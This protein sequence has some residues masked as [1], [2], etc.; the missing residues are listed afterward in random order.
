MRSISK[1]VVATAVAG[2]CGYA[3]AGTITATRSAYSLESALA[4]SA[5]VVY[6]G[7]TS[8]A[9]G[10]TALKF[11]YQ[12]QVGNIAQGQRL[13]ITST[14]RVFGTASA[15]TQT[16][17]C[18]AAGATSV[19]FV[20]AGTTAGTQVVYDVSTAATG[21]G[22]T[23]SCSIPSVAFTAAS[24]ASAGD[25][26]LAGVH[27]VTANGNTIDTFSSTIVGSVG[28]EYSFATVSTLDAVIDVAS[29]RLTFASGTDAAVSS[30]A[31]SDSFTVSV[32]KAGSKVTIGD[33][34]A[35]SFALTLTTTA[36]DFTW[37]QEPSTTAGAS[38]NCS[39]GGSGAAQATAASGA[40]GGT[41]V[42][43]PASGTCT[44]LTATFATTANSAYTIALGRSA[45]N[46]AAS[47]ATAFAPATYSAS[48]S[49]TNGTIT[50]NSGTLS[51]GSWTQNGSTINLQYVPLS[52]TSSLQVIITNTSST[53][54]TVT[55]TAYNGAGAS[56]TGDLGAVRATG[57]TSVGGLLRSALL[58]TAAAGTT[59]NCSTAFANTGFVGVT[60]V[61]STPSAS[62][63]VHSG[64]SVS[65][66]TSRGIIVNSTN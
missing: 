52:S 51:A 38:L 49:L 42:L 7:K 47:A 65:D 10:G 23:L 56:C 25:V 33:T 64:F 19:V 18:A 50:Y 60:L 8:H 45:V 1:I 54:G 16:F 15:H 11:D 20:I 57:T 35:G 14:N 24:L 43:S 41:I 48:Y 3:A 39:V 53:A 55:F 13:T 61:S 21:A 36:G 59:T 4:N 44:T 5:D 30:L 37:L 27:T 31:S 9:G 2:A 28:N 46:A 66:T 17:T 58:G 22:G 40:A 62:T 26:S 6:I 34:Y 12:T 63:R 32:S 29:N